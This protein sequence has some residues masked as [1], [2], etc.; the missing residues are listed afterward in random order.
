M[1]ST[2]TKIDAL[3]ATAGKI[4][5]DPGVSIASAAWRRPRRQGA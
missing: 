2:K 5:D 3:A 1:M 4:G